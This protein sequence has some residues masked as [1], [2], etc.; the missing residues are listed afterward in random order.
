[1][2][3]PDLSL[4]RENEQICLTIY[5]QTSL[6]LVNREPVTTSG[7]IQAHVP[8][9]WLILGVCEISRARPK[10]VIFSVLSDRLLSCIGSRINTAQEYARRAIGPLC[11]LET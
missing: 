7:A 9:V 1:M 8:A 2:E 10:S 6:D 3:K 11:K 4:L 5:L